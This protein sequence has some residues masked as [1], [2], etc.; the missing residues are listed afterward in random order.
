MVLAILLEYMVLAALYESFVYPFIT[1]VALPVSLVDAF[2]GLAISQNTLNILTMI[3]M[4]VLMGLVGKNGILLVDYANT[5][6]KEGY[7]RRE[8]LLRAGPIRLRPILMTT[9]ALVFGLMP[10]ALKLEEGSELYAG[11]GVLVI[12]GMLSST[13]LSLFVVPSSYTYF[14]DLQG[15]I[16]RVFRWRPRF[17]R[18][19]SQRAAALPRPVPQGA[20]APAG[21]MD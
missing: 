17:A 13:F 18:R 19:S 6:R 14:D 20:D 15:L 21:A 16:V 2:A 10:I 8:A 5:L 11:I 12:G 3:G 1:M 9:A 4:I 7:S